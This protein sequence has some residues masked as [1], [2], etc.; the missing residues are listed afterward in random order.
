MHKKAPTRGFFALVRKARRIA[1][2]G[3]STH[4]VAE[5]AETGFSARVDDLTRIGYHPW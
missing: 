1:N 4:A 5:V 3:Q 2:K